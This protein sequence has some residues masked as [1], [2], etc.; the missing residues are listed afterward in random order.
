MQR[1]IYR[2]AECP[3]DNPMQPNPWLT[4]LFD[5]EK[6][7]KTVMKSKS[8]SN[9]PNVS[10]TYSISGEVEQD[11]MPSTLFVDT[12]DLFWKSFL[13]DGKE[14]ETLY[15]AKVTEV[16]K[17]TKISGRVTRTLEGSKNDQYDEFMSYYDILNLLK[18]K[19]QQEVL[20]RFKRIT[21]HQGP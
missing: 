12:S 7:S 5:G 11:V 15:R 2:S 13:L 17:T 18:K 6:P 3:A 20:R 19:Q 9:Q 4:D 8:D 21:G 1:E 10:P 14:K 16:I